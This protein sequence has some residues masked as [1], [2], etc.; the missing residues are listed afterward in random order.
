M[1][2]LEILLLTCCADLST[3]DQLIIRSKYPNALESESELFTGDT[4]EWQS[5]PGRLVPSSHQRSELGNSFVGTFSR[6]DKRVWK[7]IPI[8]NG[9]VS[10][11]YPIVYFT[12]RLWFL[13]R[14]S[15]L[16][17]YL[18]I[19][20]CVL[21]GR[22]FQ[23]EDRIRMF[24]GQV[25][26][27]IITVFDKNSY[28]FSSVLFLAFDNEFLGIMYSLFGSRQNIFLTVFSTQFVVK[29]AAKILKIG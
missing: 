8:P 22:I 26:P 4:S 24:G 15:E 14:G 25:K 23:Q 10:S 5:W 7:C 2:S 28:T 13:K 29:C 6:R 11:I 1:M 20:E 16:I 9:L 21:K 3:G 17:I 18:I 19:W 12:F 27:N